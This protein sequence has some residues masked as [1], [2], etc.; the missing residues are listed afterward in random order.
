V[1][2]LVSRFS[3]K[4]DQGK[5][6]LDDPENLEKLFTEARDARDRWMRSS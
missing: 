4:L 3:G 6:L 1:L 2:V 5:K